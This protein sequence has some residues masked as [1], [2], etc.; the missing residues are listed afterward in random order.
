[1]PFKNFSTLPNKMKYNL[2]CYPIFHLVYVR[3]VCFALLKSFW[4]TCAC[5]A[6]KDSQV[7]NILHIIWSMHNWRKFPK[8]DSSSSK[9]LTRKGAH[10]SCLKCVMSTIW[11]MF[12][13]NFMLAMHYLVGLTKKK[14]N[15]KTTPMHLFLVVQ[16]TRQQKPQLI[17]LNSINYRK[18]KTISWVRMDRAAEWSTQYNRTPRKRSAWTPDLR[19][20]LFFQNTLYF[21]FML[22]STI[23]RY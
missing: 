5:L 1:M 13:S 4:D 23:H 19:Q 18:Q 17:K 7:S 21:L 22:H 10:E 9:L 6:T 2:H 11:F 12:V 3:N 15:K 8:T 14:K 16:G 20:C